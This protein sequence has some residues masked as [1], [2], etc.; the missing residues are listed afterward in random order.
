MADQIG[1]RYRLTNGNYIAGHM[2]KDSQGNDVEYVVWEKIEGAWWAFGADGYR[3]AGWV[4]DAASGLWYYIDEEKGMKTVWHLDLQDGCW[5]YLDTVS[6]QMLTGWQR[7]D[8]HWYYFSPASAA[9][10]WFYDRGS[11]KWNYDGSKGQR[12]LGAMYQNEN[13]GPVFRAGG[14][15]LGRKNAVQ[16]MISSRNTPP[17]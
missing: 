12:P 17:G 2:G 11:G 9:Q 7:I 6:G 10:T 1:R 8:G 13:T 15:E 5:Y 3:K 16:G 14:W 4:L